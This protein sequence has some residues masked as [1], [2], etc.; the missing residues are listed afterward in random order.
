MFLSATGATPIELLKIKK[1]TECKEL[2]CLTEED[3]KSFSIFDE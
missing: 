3:V 2:T 1:M